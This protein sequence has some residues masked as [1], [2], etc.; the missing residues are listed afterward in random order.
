MKTSCRW[1]SI[2]LVTLLTVS[3][4]L[5]APGIS[6]ADP[7]E[8]IG[9]QADFTH[10]EDSWLVD[11]GLTA[12]A[13]AGTNGVQLSVRED[14]NPPWQKLG[15]RQKLKFKMEDHP[16]LALS[17]NAGQGAWSVKVHD[18]NADVSLT[19][20][21][22]N[23]S[24]DFTFDI[25][26]L[27]GWT[28][29]KTFSV[30]LWAIGGNASITIDNLRIIGAMPVP[31]NP[32]DNGQ[33]PDEAADA[34]VPAS[35]DLRETGDKQR[36]DLSIPGSKI[37]INPY[38]FKQLGG[39]TASQY[40][41]RS[42]LP[43]NLGYLNTASPRTSRELADMVMLYKGI[44]GADGDV[45]YGW[46]PDI[47]D[48]TMWTIGLPDQGK[49]SDLLVERAGDHGVKLT[50]AADA[51][52][53][54]QAIYTKNM[55]T[56]NLD[57]TPMLEV[58]VSALTGRW[59]LKV[60]DGTSEYALQ[61]DSSKEGN[62]LFDIRQLTGWTGTKSFRVYLF[63]VG[64]SASVTFDNLQILS[65]T[66]QIEGA[67]SY[68][69]EW[70]PA[71]LPF[72]AAYQDG[73]AIEGEDFFYNEQTVV[74]TAD[75]SGITAANSDLYLAGKYS[76]N[77]QW[78]NQV[79]TVDQ[80][81][82]SYA[83]AVNG[84][85]SAANIRYFASESDMLAGK[86]ALTQAPAAGFWLMELDAQQLPNGK[87]IVAAAVGTAADSA[88][89][90]SWALAPLTANLPQIRA[91]REAYWDQYLTSV[92]RPERFDMP[93]IMRKGATAAAVK[94]DYYTAWVLLAQN[95]LPQD[96]AYPYPQ[97]ATGKASMWDEGEPANPFTASW[98]SLMGIQLYAY[99]DPNTAWD[100]F[101]GLMSLVQT[102]GQLGGESLPSRKAQTALILYEATGDID[103]LTDVYPA[104]T[105][106]L[107]WRIANP[108]WIYG[109]HDN[110]DERDAEFVVSALIDIQRMEEI[111]AILGRTA[112]VADWAAKRQA[113]FDQYKVWFWETPSSLPVQYYDVATGS[114][115]PANA[116]WV[117]TGLYLDEL[118][119]SYLTTML[120]LFNNWFNEEQSFAGFVNPKQPDWGYT[121]YGLINKGQTEKAAKMVEIAMRDIVRTGNVF[122]ENYTNDSP[123]VPQ[124]VRPSLF[125][126]VQLIEN[127]L[128]RNGLDY[129]K[130]TPYAVR[131]FADDN[132]VSN[133]LIRGKKLNYTINGENGMI[134]L[135]G[136]Y[137]GSSSVKPLA[138]GQSLAMPYSAGG[139]G[140][141]DS[142]GNGYIGSISNTA[143]APIVTIEDGK[144]AVKAANGESTVEI[145][146]VQISERALLVQ[147]GDAIAEFPL[148]SIRALRSQA[149]QDDKAALIVSME[150][151]PAS[152]SS[153]AAA[154]GPNAAEV[155]D[156]TAA[157]RFASDTLH[158]SIRLKLADGTVIIPELNPAETV[159]VQ[160][161]YTD[162]NMDPALLGIYLYD[163]KLKS[164][165]YMGGNIAKNRAAI[166][167]PLTDQSKVAVLEY[168]KTFEDVPPSH[169]AYRTI[170]ML[171]AKH[172]I[173]GTSDRW[174]EPA[175]VTSRA[176][177]IA[178]LA[179]A[180]ELPESG[181]A[182]PFSDV[183]D[184][185]W[186][187][188][189]ASPAYA[190]GLLTGT[191]KGTFD[192][193]ASITRQEIAVLLAR[194]AKIS[195]KPLP[196][197]EQ[198]L[199]AVKDRSQISGWAQADAGSIIA[200]GLMQGQGSGRFAP[201]SYA[202]RAEAA[203]VV[204]RFVQY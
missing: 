105:R 187:Y 100:A 194:A 128:L 190:A 96:A 176:A 57:D 200:A 59:A 64:Q 112:D 198:G 73:S 86:D 180:L 14:A 134:A 66:E 74:R 6:S 132:G 44:P 80:G 99:I 51:S 72:Q 158:I 23:D 48:Q 147:F 195:K 20:G 4:V 150:F 68:T 33:T 47:G 107:N 106:Y 181:S 156:G 131:L 160:L 124:G 136:S 78:A 76:G 137:F 46:R 153:S 89:L 95:V 169:W 18:G 82:H 185:A 154:P 8:V 28:G 2:L 26:A 177:F 110:P 85:A 164:W 149:G 83:I 62:Y 55:V 27:T 203:Q 202:T 42:T 11:P 125:G 142:G 157:V 127:V 90:A 52:P 192:P 174:F 67:I 159:S 21:D 126:M 152:S 61:L 63:A 182:P 162:E 50:V 65:V 108:R 186:Y 170:K 75:L 129:D 38:D 178:M 188:D 111:A 69:T 49:P 77:I 193:A 93:T 91:G 16:V 3:Q 10:L 168:S 39:T 88:N 165:T 138:M 191:A 94:H 163:N 92:P 60:N 161:P 30:D 122:A 114:R 29:E 9:W 130:G 146:L 79:L 133:L 36:R 118:A 12:A 116:L 204:G 102:D 7:E 32:S 135:S 98:D 97:M 54:W 34:S 151:T 13:A 101:R 196:G 15:S 172:I 166:S 40:S 141:T 53:P 19:G 113:F 58:T 45:Q 109:T 104:L 184:G 31:D 120:Q 43:L 70:T 148:N 140:G 35:A 201:M 123:P 144:A 189:A 167:I 139:S 183:P 56:V 121:I 145:P 115:N 155:S 175:A 25:A 17:V 173:S 103:S 71:S 22:R 179:Q 37:V 24:G 1:V 84:A 197:S 5:S 143:S 199:Q 119:G 81:A 87:L 41:N 117:T 171:A